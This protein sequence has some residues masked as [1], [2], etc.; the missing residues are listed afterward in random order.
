MKLKH[1]YWSKG[2]GGADGVLR[3]DVVLQSRA[4]KQAGHSGKLPVV[5]AIAV[6]LC[7]SS[8]KS[9]WESN[10]PADSSCA[11]PLAGVSGGAGKDLV[12]STSMEVCIRIYRMVT[13]Q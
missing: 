10:C 9:P 11:C 6:S 4:W 12:F 13:A 1:I 5:R 7:H 8:F 2:F 3:T